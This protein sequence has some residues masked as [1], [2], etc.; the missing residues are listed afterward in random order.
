VRFRPAGAQ[1]TF[2]RGAYLFD[3]ERPRRAAWVTVGIYDDGWTRPHTPAG[4]RVFAEPGQ[5]TP[6]QRFL[7]VTVASPDRTDDRPVTISS[8]LERWEGAIPPETA[9]DRG[10]TVC[11]APGGFATVEIETP[12]VSAV[13]RDPTHAPLT[14]EIDRPA[15]VVLRSVGLA[16]EVEPLERC[17][18][19]GGG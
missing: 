11:V 4:I 14:G 3:A 5:R 10:A 12:I 16:D 15:G 9:V 7:T 19:A 2:D 13:H 17:P 18:A 8:N 6:L 1:V